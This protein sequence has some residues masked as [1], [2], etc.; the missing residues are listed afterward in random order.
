MHFTLGGCLDRIHLP[1][2]PIL[3]LHL[4]YY[5]ARLNSTSRRLDCGKDIKKRKRETNF[6]KSLVGKKLSFI[7]VMNF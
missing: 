5:S 4:E 2:H 7:I 6:Y 1:L 3:L